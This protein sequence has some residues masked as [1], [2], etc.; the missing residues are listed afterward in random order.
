M[1]PFD[2]D[3]PKLSIKPLPDRVIV[4]GSTLTLRYIADGEPSPFL[5]RWMNI[6]NFYEVDIGCTKKKTDSLLI[7]TVYSEYI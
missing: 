1:F 6:T 2:L 5:F 3:A 7:N 4:E